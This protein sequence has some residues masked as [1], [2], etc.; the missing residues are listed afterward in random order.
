[1]GGVWERM[2]GIVRKVLNTM[3]ADLGPRYL[4]HEVLTTF[5]AT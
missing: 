5:V 4:T 2:I 1:M 3:L